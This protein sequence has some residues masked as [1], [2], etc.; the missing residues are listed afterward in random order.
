MRNI[1]GC[2]VI[3]KDKK[4]AMSFDR[5]RVTVTGGTGF[6]GSHLC[7][8]L[9]AAG[10]DVLCIDNFFTGSKDNIRHL[11]REPNFELLRH[12]ITFPIFIE[13]D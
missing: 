11:L 13:V 9:L 1:N 5:K 6:L 8:K 7:E 2:R 3:T 4:V 10:H 12:D